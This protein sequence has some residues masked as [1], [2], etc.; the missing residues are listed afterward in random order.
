MEFYWLFKAVLSRC[1]G[2]AVLWKGFK[3]CI[4]VVHLSVLFLPPAEHPNQVLKRSANIV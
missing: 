2:E 1:V 3:P 4:V